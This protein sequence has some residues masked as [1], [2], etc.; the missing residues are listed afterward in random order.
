VVLG[1]VRETRSH[2]NALPIGWPRMKELIADY[3]L[4][5]YAIGGLSRLDLEEARQAGAH[6]IAA[7]RACWTE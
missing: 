6:G 3:E 2:P 7:I 1:P 5:V 4:P